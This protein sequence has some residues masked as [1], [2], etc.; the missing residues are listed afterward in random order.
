MTSEIFELP[1]LEFK[2]YRRE[3]AF[4][5]KRKRRLCLS[6]NNLYDALSS[7]SFLIILVLCSH[8]WTPEYDNHT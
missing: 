3:N 8:S 2:G 7:H 6:K 1:G 4:H 5:E